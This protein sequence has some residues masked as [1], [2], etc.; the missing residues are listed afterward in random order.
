ML[1]AILKLICAVT[2]GTPVE[3][4]DTNSTQNR[5][6]IYCYQYGNPVHNNVKIVGI[7]VMYVIPVVLVIAVYTRILCST[8]ESITR[9]V[10]A[11]FPVSLAMSRQCKY[12]YFCNSISE[13][14]SSISV[15]QQIKTIK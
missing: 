2:M 10:R 8:S 9:Q 11:S 15:R 13:L 7:A 3:T 6:R 5:E 12:R 4:T 14:C 1:T